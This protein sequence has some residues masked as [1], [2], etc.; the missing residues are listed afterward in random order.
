[1]TEQSGINSQRTGKDAYR[2]PLFTRYPELAEKLPRYPLGSYPTPVQRL[3]H[4]GHDNLWIKRDDLTSD[5]YG[6]NKVR[7]LEFTIAEQIRAGLLPEPRRIYESE[8]SV[9]PQ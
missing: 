9:M 7:K 1:M 2:L 6:G 8:T 3:S 5:V 4:L